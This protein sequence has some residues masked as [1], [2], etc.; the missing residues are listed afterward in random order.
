MTFVID[1]SALIFLLGIEEAPEGSPLKKFLELIKEEKT[2]PDELVAP[3]LIWYELGQVL[4][5]KRREKHLALPEYQAIYQQF[6]DWYIIPI[7]FSVPEYRSIHELCLTSESTRHGLLSYY[8]ASYL[9]LAQKISAPL[10]THDRQLLTI[11]G[12]LGFQ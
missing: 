8:D 10:V 1:T 2:E 6:M 3:K 4:V 5:K 11:A 12:K 9:F 7:D